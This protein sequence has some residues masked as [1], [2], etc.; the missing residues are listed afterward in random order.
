MTQKELNAAIDAAAAMA[1]GK[2]RE[3]LHALFNNTAEAMKAFQIAN[4]TRDRVPVTIRAYV[5]CIPTDQAAGFEA[6]LNAAITAATPKAE[7]TPAQKIT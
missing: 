2:L 1:G 4:A 3:T 6:M 5:V 7:T